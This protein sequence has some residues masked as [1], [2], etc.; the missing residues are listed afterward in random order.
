MR[1][2][3][4]PTQPTIND[5]RSGWSFCYPHG[6]NDQFTLVR[7]ATQYPDFEIRNLAANGRV[8]TGVGTNERA[9][10]PPLADLAKEDHPNENKC[11]VA[12]RVSYGKFDYFT[13]GDLDVAGVETAGVAGQWKDIERP[14][15][16]VTGPVEACKANHHANYDANSAFFLGVLRPQVIV[17]QTWG[18]SQP[19]MNVY[20]RMLSTATYPGRRDVFLTNLPAAT[21]AA[22]HIEKTKTEQGHIV[23]RVKPGG[24]SFSVYVLDD[25]DEE[26]RIKA[27]HGPYACR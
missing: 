9:H 6:R 18:A 17:A 3:P 16:L 11:S 12:I 7:A 2:Q 25:T 19:S 4:A 1:T 5:F 20:R 10:F 22:L 27:V 14:V 26:Q 13:G 21:A 8:W 15:A 24:E 23:I